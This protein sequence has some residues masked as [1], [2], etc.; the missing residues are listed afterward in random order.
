[1]Q[2]HP[3]FKD[4]AI[5][6]ET[7]ISSLTTEVRKQQE[8]L[9]TLFEAV[10]RKMADDELA[11]LQ[12]EKVTSLKD[13]AAQ[14]DLMKEPA[15][16]ADLMKDTAAQADLHSAR[17]DQRCQSDAR[18][19][20]CSALSKFGCSCP[21]LKRLEG[22]HAMGPVVS[23]HSAA[24]AVQPQPAVEPAQPTFGLNPPAVVLIDRV[25]A[26]LQAYEAEVDRVCTASS[27]LKW[28]T[29]LSQRRSERLRQPTETLCQ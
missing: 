22:A 19:C 14:A 4:L 2:G 25:L 1:M 6:Q 23:T 26:S 8:S 21:F 12:P 10:K 15:A 5:E 9:R 13:T 20:F 27:H 24:P 18:C 29:G 16:Q 3:A 28:S 11:A 17:Q 7:S